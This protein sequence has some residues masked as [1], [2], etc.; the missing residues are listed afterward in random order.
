MAYFEHVVSFWC[1]FLDPKLTTYLSNIGVQII[2]VLELHPPT[3]PKQEV[4]NY[5]SYL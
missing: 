4:T 3:L 5:V 2:L 1:P